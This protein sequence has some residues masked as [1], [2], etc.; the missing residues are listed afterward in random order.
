MLSALTVS[1]GYLVPELDP[2]HTRYSASVGLSPVTVTVSPTNDHNAMIRFLDENGLVLADADRTSAGFQVEFGGGVPAV[3]IRVVSQD[4]QATHTYTVTDLGEKYDANDD[5]A[6]QRD[7]VITA[8]AD[9]FDDFITREE[10]I[11][12]IELYFFS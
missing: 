3:E 11:A 1:P 6:I 9:Y 5:G 12:V 4:G 10:V 2:Y 7:E 8:I